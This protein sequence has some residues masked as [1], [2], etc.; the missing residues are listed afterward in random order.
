MYKRVLFLTVAMTLRAVAHDHDSPSFPDSVALDTTYNVDLSATGP[1]FAVHVRILQ[2]GKTYSRTTQY[3]VQFTSRD[4]AQAVQTISDS[5]FFLP[6]FHRKS[7]G[8][9]DAD[10]YPGDDDFKPAVTYAIADNEFVQFVDMN[11]DGYTDLRLLIS[12]GPMGNFSYRYWLYDSHS[13]TFRADS[14]LSY[15]CSYPSLDHRHKIIATMGMDGW[16]KLQ[17][18]GGQLVRIEYNERELVEINGQM[19]CRHTRFQLI[20]GQM[21][22]TKVTYEDQ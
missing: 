7:G 12:E 3:L 17:F 11:F 8:F 13:S 22:A 20:D 10:Y 18:K 5:A 19:K 9:R 6:V 2:P 14:A 21:K 16:D 15:Y 4:N 1:T